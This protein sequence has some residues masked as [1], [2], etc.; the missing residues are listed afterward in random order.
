MLLC[1]GFLFKTFSTDKNEAVEDMWSTSFFEAAFGVAVKESKVTYGRM[2]CGLAKAMLKING[3]ANFL[4]MV[5]QWHCDQHTGAEKAR[6]EF[7][8][9]AIRAVDWSH[10]AGSVRPRFKGCTWQ[11]EDEFSTIWRTGAFKVSQK[12]AVNK[13]LVEI[14]RSMVCDTRVLPAA[15]FSA[16][17]RRILA[18]MEA[19]L[20]SYS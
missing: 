4:E 5:L 1:L 18:W 16:V 20:P 15:A 10:F 13:D 17:W 9:H 19:C 2:L 6:Q 11:C 8:A 3:V 14:L 7:L 12:V